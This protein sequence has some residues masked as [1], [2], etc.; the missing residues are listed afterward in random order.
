ML[1]YSFLWNFLQLYWAHLKYV[2]QWF[3]LNS[4][5]Y[6]T[7][8]TTVEYF[9]HLKKETLPF[10]HHISIN[11]HLLSVSIDFPLLNVSYEWNHSTCGLVCLAFPTHWIFSRFIQVVGC[12]S[13]SFHFMT[14]EYPI[15]WRYHSW[16]IHHLMDIWFVFTF[17]LL[18][19]LLMF[20]RCRYFVVGIC[21]H[22][23]W[24]YS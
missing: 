22:F 1:A 21:F 4:Q 6:V 18:W 24:V 19:V 13:T 10:S 9:H 23:T 3:S 12:I 20:F 14:E 11:H 17:W 2:I 16:T 5:I 7:I 8:I 15:V